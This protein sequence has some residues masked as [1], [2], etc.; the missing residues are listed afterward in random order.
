VFGGTKGN[1]MKVFG[2]QLSFLLFV[3]AYATAR[4]EATTEGVDQLKAETERL[5]AGRVPTNG[6]SRADESKPRS[7]QTGHLAAEYEKELSNIASDATKDKDTRRRATAELARWKDP[8]TTPLLARLLKDDYDAVRASAAW[9]LCQIGGQEAQDALLEYLRTSLESHSWSD[10]T[11]ATEAQEVLPDA[12][13]LDLLIKCLNTENGGNSHFRYTAKALGKIGNPKASVAIAH[14][15]DVNIEYSMSLD[16]LYRDAIRKTKGREAV[17]ILIDYLDRLVAKMAGQNP[18]E[19]YTLDGW[20]GAGRQAQYN[21]QVFLLVI[22]A[23]ESTAGRRTVGG[24]R[25]EVSGDWKEWLKKS[26]EDSAAPS[27]DP[28]AGSR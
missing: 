13:A 4:C 3:L 27:R 5:E 28:A 2:I 20:A 22:S 25:E 26:G 11:R 7:Q 21:N 12:R 1:T 6:A 8:S 10:L 23:L 24:S 16:Y 9:G 17:P 18:P 19:L 14:R 15:L